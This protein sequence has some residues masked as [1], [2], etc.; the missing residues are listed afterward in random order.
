MSL[1]Q[2]KSWREKKTSITLYLNKWRQK[3]KKT[4]IQNLLQKETTFTYEA[5]WTTKLE[6]HSSLHTQKKSQ[7]FKWS[8]FMH[9]AHGK[10]MYV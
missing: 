9:D 3:Y 7:W 10:D 6:T 5:K 2:Q 4:Y 8:I 1:Q